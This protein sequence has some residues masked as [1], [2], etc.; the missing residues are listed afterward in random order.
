M[1]HFCAVVAFVSRVRARRPLARAGRDW[2]V[3]LP[4]VGRPATTLQNV[5]D[6]SERKLAHT[7][8]TFCATVQQAVSDVHVVIDHG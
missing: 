1:P 8:V 2:H 6:G 5:N 3:L 4:S 7:I